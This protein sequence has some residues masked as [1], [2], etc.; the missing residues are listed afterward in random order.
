MLTRCKNPGFRA[1][2]LT[3]QN[4]FRFLFNK[5]KKYI[6]H[7]WLLAPARKVYLLPKK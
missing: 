5:Y 3:G 6:F 2:Y 7:F 4:K 1:L